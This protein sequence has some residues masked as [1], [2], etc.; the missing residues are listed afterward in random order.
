MYR[1]VT[2]GFLTLARHFARG[3]TE[4]VDCFRPKTIHRLKA[5]GEVACRACMPHCERVLGYSAS[6]VRRTQFKRPVQF[7]RFSMKEGEK[8]GFVVYRKWADAVKAIQ[9]GGLPSPAASASQ[10]MSPSFTSGRAMSITRALQDISNSAFTNVVHAHV[11][12]RSWALSL[13]GMKSCRLPSILSQDHGTAAGASAGAKNLAPRR[14][15]VPRREGSGGCCTIAR[16]SRVLPRRSAVR[17]PYVLAFD[18]LHRAERGGLPYRP[19]RQ[20]RRQTKQALP[21]LCRERL[22]RKR[23]RWPAL[24]S[25]CEYQSC[26]PWD[27]LPRR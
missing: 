20:Q 16:S 7:P 23:C 6:V 9:A 15:L 8:W 19:S 18:L 13:N 24:H 3:R 4:A 14:P 27:A 26:P 11:L 5:S 17:Q 10:R 2:R 21:D 12:Q 22:S 1:Q 25:P